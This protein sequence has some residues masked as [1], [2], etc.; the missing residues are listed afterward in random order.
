MWLPGI[1]FRLLEEQPM[2][3]T[4]EPSL[5]FVPACIIT[6]FVM[7][8]RQCLCMQPWLSGTH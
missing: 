5:Q 4:A 1:E 7:H 2:L 3:S 6:S 8:L